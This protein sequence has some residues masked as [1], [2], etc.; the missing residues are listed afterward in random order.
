MNWL[1]EKIKEGCRILFGDDPVVLD[2]IVEPKKIRKKRKKRKLKD[3]KR[4]SRV[5]KKSL[6]KRKKR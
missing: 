4:N 2:E 5:K 6:R 1:F 3:W